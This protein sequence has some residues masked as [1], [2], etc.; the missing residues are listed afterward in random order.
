MET[1]FIPVGQRKTLKD[2]ITGCRISA[3]VIGCLMDADGVILC[4]IY[5]DADTP[6]ISDKDKQHVR[7]DDGTWVE[8]DR[9][10]HLMADRMCWS[11]RH[12]RGRA[13]RYPLDQPDQHLWRTARRHQSEGGSDT[14]IDVAGNAEDRT[15]GFAQYVTNGPML[16]KSDTRLTLKGPTGRIDL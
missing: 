16:V 1:A 7:F 13:N 14:R 5:S 9:K 10:A 2:R 6:P 12:S 15:A 8:Y 4:S 11:D 3:S